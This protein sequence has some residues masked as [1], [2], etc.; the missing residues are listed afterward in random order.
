MSDWYDRQRIAEMFK[1]HK[2]SIPPVCPAPPPAAAGAG[3][4]GSLRDRIAEWG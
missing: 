3:Q 4:E 1:K 2:E